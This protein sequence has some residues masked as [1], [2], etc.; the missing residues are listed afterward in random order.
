MI[1]KILAVVDWIFNHPVRLL[2]GAAVWFAVW[3]VAATLGANALN[4]LTTPMDW[5]AAVGVGICI[6]ILLP[7]VA[8]AL[9]VH[10]A[11]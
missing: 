11:E 7:L 1:Q 5:I 4:M 8:H 6:G 3:I 2:V 10:P 9:A